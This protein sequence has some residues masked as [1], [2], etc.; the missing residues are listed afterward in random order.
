MFSALLL[1]SYVLV[2]GY[3]VYHLYTI[4]TIYDLVFKEAKHDLLTKCASLNQY[5]CPNLLQSSNETDNRHKFMESASWWRRHCHEI[6][7]E[8][9]IVTDVQ[10]LEQ[11]LLH[12]SIERYQGGGHVHIYS[13]EFLNDL[14]YWLLEHHMQGFLVCLGVNL[15]AVAIVLW[16]IVAIY[17]RVYREQ[18]KHSSSSPSIS[19]HPPSRP[20]NGSSAYY[21]HVGNAGNGGLIHRRNGVREHPLM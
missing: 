4:T 17:Y 3:I 21:N 2:S 16:L 12:R 11:N 10:Q 20:M 13:I 5:S 14:V 9:E 8:T 15:L 19:I 18:H 7:N 6:I 1:I